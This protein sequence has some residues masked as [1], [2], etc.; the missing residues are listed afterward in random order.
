MG[1]GRSIP[2]GWA[3]SAAGSVDLG[4]AVLTAFVV[5]LAF[6]RV[7]RVEGAGGVVVFE[8]LPPFEVLPLGMVVCQR[9]VDFRFPPALVG[10]SC[11]LSLL[12]LV[13]NHYFLRFFPTLP[14]SQSDNNDHN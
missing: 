11:P 7:V 8:F 5:W 12:L 9:G 14:T 3:E 4:L 6:D 10:F 1:Q 13:P 2:F